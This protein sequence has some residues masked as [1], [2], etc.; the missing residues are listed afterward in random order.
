MTIASKVNFI[1]LKIDTSNMV[2]NIVLESWE[3]AKISQQSS[4]FKS[5]A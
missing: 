1:G 5:I 2:F 4:F 3:Q